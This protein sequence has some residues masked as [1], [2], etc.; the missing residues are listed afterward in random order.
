L[1]GV[2]SVFSH[3]FLKIYSF[4][5]FNVS[6][7]NNNGSWSS[8]SENLTELFSLWS[9]SSSSV[10]VCIFVLLF[11][12]F[13]LPDEADDDDDVDEHDEDVKVQS[14]CDPFKI[15]EL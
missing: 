4:L 11:V 15:S 12:G 9:W 1:I 8:E 10:T 2:A 13:L 7:V 3:I 6:S 5:D 14:K